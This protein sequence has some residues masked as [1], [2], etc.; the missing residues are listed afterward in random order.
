MNPVAMKPITACGWSGDWRPIRHARSTEPDSLD[1]ARMAYDQGVIELVQ[2]RHRDELGRFWVV[3]Y[4]I[5]RRKR[6]EDHLNYFGTRRA[7]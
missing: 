3:L 6:R 7:A 2:G 5:N 1:E 4:A